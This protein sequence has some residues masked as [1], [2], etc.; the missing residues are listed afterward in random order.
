MPAPGPKDGHASKASRDLGGRRGLTREIKN[1]SVKSNGFKGDGQGGVA[2]TNRGLAGV[3]LGEGGSARSVAARQRLRAR[4]LA[5]EAG[6]AAKAARTVGRKRAREAAAAT[7]TATTTA[8]TATTTTAAAVAADAVEGDV[9]EAKSDDAHVAGSENDYFCDVCA[10]KC[11][12]RNNYETHVASKRHR[13]NRDAARGREILA[14]LKRQR[15]EISG[16]A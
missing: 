3:R 6:K 12:S 14:S 7:A 11:G 2:T 8:A 13:Q 4:F 15:V 10:C 5:G 1:V 9:V 16:E